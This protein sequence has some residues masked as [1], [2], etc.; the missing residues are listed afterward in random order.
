MKKLSLFLEFILLFVPVFSQNTSVLTYR[1]GERRLG[2]NS[3][4]SIL[5]P[6]NVNTEKF[7]FLF[8]RM[9]DDDVYAQPLIVSNLLINGSKQNVVFIATVNN[10][11][12]AFNADDPSKSA[13]LWKVSLTTPGARVFNKSDLPCS[14]FNNNI[15]IVGT[16]VIDTNTMTIFAL[17]HDVSNSTGKSQ[18]YLHAIDIRTGAEKEH[19]PLAIKAYCL[20]SGDGSSNDTIVFDQ[21]KHNQRTALLLHNGVIYACWASHCDVAPYHGWVM[22]FDTA[23]LQIKYVYNDTPMGS[24]GGIWMAGNAPS[25]D[26]Q[27]NIYIISG[28]GDVGYNGNPNDKRGRGES[29]LKFFPTADSLKLVNYFTPNNYNYLELND[30]DYGIGGAMLIPNSSLS[31][32]NSKEGKIFLLDDDRLGKYSS[33]NDSLLQSVTLVNQSDWYDF[34]TPVYYRYH[35]SNDSEFVYV[36]A[37]KNKLNQLFFDRIA[38]TFNTASTIYGS[39]TA[40]QFSNYG[41]VLTVSSNGPTPGT[42]IVWALRPGSSNTGI[43]EAF[44]AK[45][46]R[47][48]LWS[49]DMGAS[50]NRVSSWAK[51][52]T[53]MVA[54]GKVY[55][56]TF[57]N[58]LEVY[59]LLPVNNPNGIQTPPVLDFVEIYPNP[60]GESFTI[61]YQVNSKLNNLTLRIADISGRKLLTRKLDS[62]MGENSVSIELGKDYA[63]G[64]YT[65]TLY[66]DAGMIGNYRFIKD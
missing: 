9:V 54:N 52:N 62:N 1:Y 3:S 22:G 34:G 53:A 65:I 61:R 25:V 50:T 44:D 15:G 16:P 26:D 43:L 35:Q 30:L 33:G 19:S 17:S 57:S 23:N 46:V 2:W 20:G 66:S 32:S 41:P 31:V 7:G 38:D 40:N 49:S 24:D 12:Y 48:L 63:H 18:Q 42:C 55:V 29:L 59:G 14:N 6:Q 10:S 27:G 4:E 28:N 51:F 8:N 64:F 39:I 11:L 58:K 60:V 13:P 36:W 47:N 45:D 21:T 56:P 37:S 5:N